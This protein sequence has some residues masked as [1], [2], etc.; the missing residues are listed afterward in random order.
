MRP[1][2]SDYNG[3]GIGGACDNEDSNVAESEKTITE[4]GGENMENTNSEQPVSEEGNYD[5]GSSDDNSNEEQDNYDG[6]NSE[7]Q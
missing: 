2:Q 1:D 3:G 5:G 6:S 7:G 4:G